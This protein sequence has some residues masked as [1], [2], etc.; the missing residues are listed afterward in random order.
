LG[1]AIQASEGRVAA[2]ARRTRTSGLTPAGVDW[3]LP[4]SSPSTTTLIPSVP[5]DAGARQL[6][7]TNPSTTR[8]AVTVE[9]LGIQGPFAPA[10]ADAVEIQP[11]S[12]ATLDLAPGLAGEA[13]TIRLTS[14]QPVTGAVISTSQRSGA[15]ADLAVQSAA[16]PLVRT[17]VSALATA[18]NVDAELSIS[19][20]GANDTPVTF[21]ILSLQG[22]VLRSDDV[23]LTPGTTATR[24]LSSPAPSYVVVHVPA[25]SAVVGGVVLTQSDGDIAGLAT[26]PLTSPDLASRAPS[27]R[28]DPAVGR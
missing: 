11:E 9:V 18:D 16:A 20:G 2:V 22:V 21:E 24:R 19:N 3:Q 28:P 23:L 26:V 4:S 6:V 27:T 15:Q 25:G 5:S 7:V 13:A 10:G 1:L 12:S 17:G 8:A 14:D